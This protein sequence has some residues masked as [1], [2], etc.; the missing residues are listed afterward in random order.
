MALNRG[1]RTE[2]RHPRRSP[3]RATPSKCTPP[4]RSSQHASIGW[5]ATNRR[6]PSPVRLK[7]FSTAFIPE[8]DAAIINLREVLGDR[9]CESLARKGKSMTTAAIAAYALYQI[10]QARTELNAVSK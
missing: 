10:D 3:T 1:A 7:P 8:L 4:W 6:P 9:T 5:A 2:E